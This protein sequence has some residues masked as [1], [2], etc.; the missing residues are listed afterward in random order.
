MHLLKT[1]YGLGSRGHH[2][3]PQKCKTSSCVTVS[4]SL[5]SSLPL[6][7]SDKRAVPQLL[8]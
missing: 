7:V 3:T 6:I 4:A 5:S 2:H 1:Q 8:P